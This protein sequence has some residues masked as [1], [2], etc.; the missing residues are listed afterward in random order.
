MRLLSS[1][2]MVCALALE[3]SQESVASSV[4]VI[5]QEIRQ[6]CRIDVVELQL[7]QQPRPWQQHSWAGVVRAVTDITQLAIA[8][9]WSTRRDPPA[10]DCAR[11]RLPRTWVNEAREHLRT[12]K[13]SASMSLSNVAVVHGL[14]VARKFVVCKSWDWHMV[15]VSCC[16]S[17]TGWRAQSTPVLKF[18][19][20]VV[21]TY[22][23]HG[24]SRA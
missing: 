5:L 6:F 2:G 19:C 24:D 17:D 18:S 14:F 12:S 7:L 16:K 10:P 15:E 22:L 1:S 9:V 13:A 4:S 23:D 21:A 8:S 11:Q 3:L 20:P